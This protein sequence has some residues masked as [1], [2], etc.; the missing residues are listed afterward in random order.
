MRVARQEDGFSLTDGEESLI[1]GLQV[2]TSAAPNTPFYY[3]HIP[4]LSGVNID[5][6]KFIRSASARIDSF[7]GIKYS[8]GSTLYNLQSMQE[9]YNS[10]SPPASDADTEGMSDFWENTHFGSTTS[11]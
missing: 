6:C 3:Y 1:D 7:V 10:Y 4:F 5:I 9:T 11:R 8:D 2:I